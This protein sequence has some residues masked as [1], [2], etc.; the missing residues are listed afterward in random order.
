MIAI[1][2]FKLFDFPIFDKVLGIT[3]PATGGLSLNEFGNWTL[4]YEIPMVIFI[5]TGILALMYK[6]SFSKFI[7]GILE[8]MKKAFVP[9]LTMFIAYF[10]LIVCVQNLF[11]LQF[12]KFFLEITNGLNVITMSLA[13]MFSSLFNMDAVYIAQTTLPYVTTV[14]TDT[15]LYSLI[16]VMTQ[17]MYGLVMLIAPTSVILIGVLSYLDIPYLQWIKHIWKLFL[18]LLVVLL[19]FFLILVLV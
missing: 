14:I 5:F 15:S 18:E 6:V 11:Q 10:I 17:A 7:E 16:A 4:N 9:A 12:T 1:K 19:I 8:G 3:N 13:L 2:E